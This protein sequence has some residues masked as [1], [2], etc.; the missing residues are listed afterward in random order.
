MCG[1]QRAELS[2]LQGHPQDEQH[3][4]RCLVGRLKGEW[5]N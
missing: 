5:L 4:V 3:R 2:A 1:R